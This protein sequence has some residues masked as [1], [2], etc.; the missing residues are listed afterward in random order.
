MYARVALM[1]AT[2]QMPEHCD[3]DCPRSVCR[4]KPAIGYNRSTGKWYCEECS[5]ALN[6][7]NKKD[8][9]ELFGGDL[10]VIAS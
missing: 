5:H 3:E 2:G 6:R 9:M 10:V 7:E 4:N 8:A 1:D